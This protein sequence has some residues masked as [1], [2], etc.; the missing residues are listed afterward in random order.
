[1]QILKKI[2]LEKN[3][4]G[5]QFLKYSMCG[6][7]ALAVDMIVAFFVA[8]LWLPALNG[9]ELFVKWFGLQF[10]AVSEATRT[11]NFVIG[12]IIAFFLSN[13]TAY[14]LNVLFVFKAGKHSRWKEIGM[15]YLVSGISVGI[16]VA[17]G[18]SLIPWLGLP[19]DY[20]Y[21]AKAISTTLINYV[22]RKYLIFKG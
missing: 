7:T 14:I 9:D 21:I 2:L 5:I 3:H 10:D 13:L 4:A 20:S 15:F 17:I 6:C 19:Y 11:T 16:G 1:M 18:A 12:S 8:W 22:A